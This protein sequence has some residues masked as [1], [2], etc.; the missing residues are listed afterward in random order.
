MRIRTSEV[1]V[2]VEALAE[3]KVEAA[4]VV[5]AVVDVLTPTTTNRNQV[6]G[7]LHSKIKSLDPIKVNHR[8]RGLTHNLRN[9]ILRQR[10]PLHQRKLLPQLP[11]SPVVKFRL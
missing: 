5:E 11:N 8:H 2:V 3:E 4:A 10:L 7:R 1:V 9:R 6:D